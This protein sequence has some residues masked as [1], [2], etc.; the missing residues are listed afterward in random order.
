MDSWK[1]ISELCRMVV[2]TQRV[3]LDILI[4]E[5]GMEVMLFP[6][7]GKNDNLR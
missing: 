6:M 4:T 2:E 5:N 7:E 1:L 3:Y